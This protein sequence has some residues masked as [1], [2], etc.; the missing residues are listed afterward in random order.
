MS[1]ESLEAL[2]RDQERAVGMLKWSV[3][4]AKMELMN[5]EFA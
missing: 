5:M 2:I 4:D 1:R 3:E